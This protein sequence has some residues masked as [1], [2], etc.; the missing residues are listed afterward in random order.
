MYFKYGEIS[1]LE[2]SSRLLNDKSNGY[3]LYTPN[4][5]EMP[6]FIEAKIASGQYKEIFSCKE[7]RFIKIF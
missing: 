6:P 1:K 4:Q 5:K 2:P 3:L 7:Y